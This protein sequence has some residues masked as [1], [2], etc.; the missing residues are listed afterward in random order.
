MLGMGASYP[1][2]IVFGIFGVWRYFRIKKAVD[3][4]AE[5]AD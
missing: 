1:L 4:A 3:K 5:H 2:A